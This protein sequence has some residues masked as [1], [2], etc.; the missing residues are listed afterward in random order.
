MFSL[1]SRGQESLGCVCLAVRVGGENTEEDSTGRRDVFGMGRGG[2]LTTSCVSCCSCM[3]RAVSV[4]LM[5]FSKTFC[6]SVSS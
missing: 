6:L 3:V 2:G 5:L 4:V 1:K